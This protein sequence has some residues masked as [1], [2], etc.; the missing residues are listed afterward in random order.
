MYVHYRVLHNSWVCRQNKECSRSFVINPRHLFCLSTEKYFV[1]NLLAFLRTTKLLLWNPRRWTLVRPPS[2]CGEGDE[3]SKHFLCYCPTFPHISW[4]EADMV[5]AN[6]LSSSSLKWR[7]LFL[8]KTENRRLLPGIT[9]Y[10]YWVCVLQRRISYPD[11]NKT[12]VGRTFLLTN[13]SLIAFTE[14]KLVEIYL[15]E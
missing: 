13:F 5:I 6:I 11:R 2:A 9:M 7:V 4:L 14:C 10:Q 12:K 3:I 15:S 8:W 1:D